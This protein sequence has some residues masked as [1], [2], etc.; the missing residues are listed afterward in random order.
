MSNFFT[1]DFN[2]E[3]AIAPWNTSLE[4]TPG[5][6]P[7]LDANRILTGGVGQE[8]NIPTLTPN[9]YDNIILPDASPTLMAKALTTDSSTS[10]QDSSVDLLT[11][12]AMSEVY[13]DLSKFAA[14]PDFVTK[15]NVAFGENWDAAGAK[16]LAEGWFNRDFSAIPPVKVVSSAEIG[17]ANGAFA[18]ATDTIY[19]SKEFLAQNGANPAAVA[20]VLLEEIGHSVDARLNVTDSPGDEGAIFAAVVQGKDLS[21]GELKALK[22]EDDREVVAID[23]QQYLIEKQLSSFPIQG[24]IR[25]YYDRNPSIANQLGQSTGAE[26]QFVSSKWRQNF[27]NG[28]IFHS[29]DGT[30]SVRGSLGNHYLNSLGGQNSQLGLPTSEESQLPLNSGNWRQSFEKGTLEW[31]SNGTPRV[32]LTQNQVPANNW[33]AEYFNN[34][35]LTGTPVFV[36]NLGDG[37]QRFSRNWGTGSPTNTPSDNFSARIT[38]Q[39]YLAPG[40][41]KIETQADDG[42]RVS[43]KNQKVIDQWN[44]KSF[45]TNSGYFRSSGETVPI[46]VE[47][48]ELG[49]GAALNFNLIPATKFQESVNP[50]QE[51]KATVYS[52]NSSQGSA[53]PTNF[54]E[55]DINNPNAIGVINL[56]SNTRGDGKK[57]IKANWG[58]GAPN[59]DG[60]RLPHDFFAMRAYT[61]A[62]FDGS[63]YKFRVEGDDGFRLL[64]RNQSTSQW[65]DITSPNQ[66]TES[67]SAK[68]VTA[69]LPA[70]QY[71]MYFDQYEGGGD[72]RFDLSWEKV[73]LP[74]TPFT[75]QEYFQQL[76]GS[77]GSSSR[78]FSAHGA[79]DSTDAIAPYNVRA[80]VGG[81]VVSV[82]SNGVE[83]QYVNAN[84]NSGYNPLTRQWVTASNHNN[85]VTIW[86]PDL[87]RSFTYLHFNQV[88]VRQGESV[89]PGQIIGIEGSTGWST[90][91]HTHLA[92]TNTSNTT[93]DPL[94]TL[95]R[96][97]GSGVISKTYK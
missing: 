44:Y 97:R 56:G 67:Y 79:I 47:Y 54:W 10:L 48:S 61:Q 95:G 96:A 11:G 16:A 85:S 9:A 71:D 51:W 42:I 35:N 55:G 64:A 40:L 29:A 21:Q 90:G 34:T 57:G 32:T 17:G 18:A 2:N 75:Q 50:S 49:G 43:I 80:L 6:I 41:Y 19:L 81:Q 37:I 60:N 14:E 93:E 89:N 3:S 27:Q 94:V 20:D 22:S 4:T 46:A 65:F 63:S 59:G 77:A 58:T 73:S 15:M 1:P 45:A 25:A 36:E 76:Y 72:A 86:N 62:N 69:E 13:E 12:Q 5:I 28:A 31:L 91:R 83:L 78:G 8:V 88:N 24:S 92:V 84:A 39:R 53:P 33:K 38:T 82:K 87:Q 30:Y 66:W 68:D 52:W 23:G 70:G 7:K 74:S 26:Y